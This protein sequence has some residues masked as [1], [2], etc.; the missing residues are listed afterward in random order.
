[1]HSG[2]HFILASASKHRLA[3]LESID[4]A[5][6]A[7]VPADIDETPLKGESPE[8]FVLRV[9]EGKAQKI[10]EA[11][12]NSYVIAADTI[13]VVGTQII[14]KAETKDEARKTLTLLSGRRHR[15]Y[16]GLCVI[17]PNGKQSL[18]RV[19][20]KVK[21][22]LIGD[23]ELQAYLD[24]NEW[25]GKSGCYGIQSRGGGFVES[26]NGS[27]SNVVGLPLVEVSRILSGLGYKR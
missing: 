15:V 26:L 7:V 5:P 3:L 12:P 14:G 20:T 19:T 4:L 23:A 11:Y 10:H 13:G 16:T 27:F 9:A 21:F 2:H 25:V 6:D 8:Q 24:S 18:R 1:M 17:A 22:T